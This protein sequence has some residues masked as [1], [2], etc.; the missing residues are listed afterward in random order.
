MEETCN[1]KRFKIPIKC[2]DQ[3]QQVLVDTGATISTVSKKVA[4]KLGLTQFVI[5]TQIIRYGNRTMQAT[6][7]KAMMDFTFNKT[8]SSRAYLL[9]VSEQNEDV[10]L[11]MDW[12]DKEDILL[13]PK[14]KSVTKH[15][16]SLE[17]VNSADLMIEEMLAK[18]PSLTDENDQQTIT[19]APYEHVIDTGEV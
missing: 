17:Q 3:E 18:Y 13:R 19:T 16:N 12:M 9:V 4:D 8:E 14:I 7:C 1:R 10:I 6:N 2:N 15:T 5:D 11:G